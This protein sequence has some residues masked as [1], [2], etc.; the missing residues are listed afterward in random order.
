MFYREPNC[1]AIYT[2]EMSNNMGK[3]TNY[4]MI[5]IIVTVAYV[6]TIFLDG[7]I[8]GNED[9]VLSFGVPIEASDSHSWTA[10]SISWAGK[11]MYS[12]T[13]LIHFISGCVIIT[14]YV[15]PT[16][17]NN[18]CHLAPYEEPFSKECCTCNLHII[19]ACVKICR[20][21][22]AKVS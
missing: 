13:N 22:L 20:V 5:T 7:S 3:S 9:L 16:V 12:I 14:K 1:V 8:N 11:L 21:Q 18:E 17:H 6:R 4:K 2:Q 19:M 10:K 15:T